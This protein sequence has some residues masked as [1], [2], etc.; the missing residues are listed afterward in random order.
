VYPSRL[1]IVCGASV[2]AAVKEIMPGRRNKQKRDDT[3]ESSVAL[4]A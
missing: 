1:A 2:W 3:L 4:M